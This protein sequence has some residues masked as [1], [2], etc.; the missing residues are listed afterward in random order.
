M[1][2]YRQV[3]V[4]TELRA[5]LAAG[6]TSPITFNATDRKYLF[7]SVTFVSFKTR[8]QVSRITDSISIFAP[9]QMVRMPYR[10]NMINFVLR[11]VHM[12]TAYLLSSLLLQNP[13]SFGGQTGLFRLLKFFKH[14]LQLES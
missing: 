14:F 11:Y 2:A 4:K 9:F 6:L 12:E 10:K 3:T 8:S 1:K 13:N 7:F 5:E